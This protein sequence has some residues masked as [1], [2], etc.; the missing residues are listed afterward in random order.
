MALKYNEAEAEVGKN[1]PAKKGVK[2][3]VQREKAA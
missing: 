1:M 2:V 3:F